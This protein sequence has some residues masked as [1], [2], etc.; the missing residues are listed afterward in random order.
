M[1][2]TGT[3]EL[4]GDSGRQEVDGTPQ[5]RDSF[6]DPVGLGGSE[7]LSQSVVGSASGGEGPAPG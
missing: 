5:P 7:T 6:V 2:L 4:W 3:L 1:Q